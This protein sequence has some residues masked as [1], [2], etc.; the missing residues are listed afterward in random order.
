[1]KPRVLIISGLDPS[2]AAGL[3]LDSIIS[4]SEGVITSGVPTCLV[5]ENYRTV[6]KIQIVEPDLLRSSI[7]L[8]L[9]EGDFKATKIGLVPPPLVDDLIDVI[10]KR[11]SQLGYIVFDPVL[12]SSSG[13]NFYENNF[14]LLF[15]LFRCSNM[16]TPNIEEFEKL[17][18]ISKEKIND[19]EL[20][21]CLN[22][23]KPASLLITSF[24][25]ENGRITNL[26][27]TSSKTLI[28]EVEETKY[29]VRGTG[30]ALSSLIAT[31]VAKGY[32]PE[33]AIKLS[34]KKVSELVK[35]S[36]VIKNGKRRFI[37]D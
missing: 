31:F 30:C 4:S 11:K 16:I 27:V 18:K 6:E 3:L 13:F 24:K 1:M 28:F 32:K 23:I 8:V 29:D 25:R 19:K 10:S 2:G 21:N 17:F 35:V 20:T 26:Y 34:M 15:G 9:E 14:G 22:S 5:A 36:V 33:E 12:F 37:L 7:N